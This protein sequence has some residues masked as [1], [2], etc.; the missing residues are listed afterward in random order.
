MNRLVFAELSIGHSTFTVIE[1]SRE[2]A[3]KLL[4]EAFD[5]YREQKP[6]YPWADYRVI[7]RDMTVGEV[8]L[9][10]V[11]YHMDPFNQK[12]W[13]CDYVQCAM[14]GTWFAAE[15]HPMAEQVAG[16]WIM[17][18]GDHTPEE[19]AEALDISEQQAYDEMGLVYPL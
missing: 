12:R 17:S 13:P 18:P 5:K 8:M 11:G 6:A 9:D 3:Q 4:R 15:D 1:E 7:F 14:T 2:A 16:S 19:V 10:G